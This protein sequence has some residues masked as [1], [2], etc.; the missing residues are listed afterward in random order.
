M[1]KT[2]SWQLLGK[3]QVD[4]QSHITLSREAER[5]ERAAER[6]CLPPVLARSRKWL[7]INRH[8]EQLSTLHELVSD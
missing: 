4:N 3:L 2:E 1:A 5:E 8:R 7:T 6:S